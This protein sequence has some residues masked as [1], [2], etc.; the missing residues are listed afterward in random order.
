MREEEEGEEQGKGDGRQP[1]L[2][3]S[4]IFGTQPTAN[5][6]RAISGCNQ[7][8]MDAFDIYRLKSFR[9]HVGHSADILRKIA[10][11]VGDISRETEISDLQQGAMASVRS[12]FRH[13]CMWMWR[14]EKGNIETN[15]ASVILV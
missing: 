15:L 8:K 12:S 1:R 2:E 9:R 4:T 7:S 13:V 10:I 14:E 11:R 3:G 6:M 5:Q